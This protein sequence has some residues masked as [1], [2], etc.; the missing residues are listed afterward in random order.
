MNARPYRQQDYLALKAATRRA[1][2]E[3]GTLAEVAKHTRTH[4]SMLSKYGNPNEHEFA[5]IDVAMD[6]DALAG[7]D[8]ILRAWAEM[9][10]YDLVKDERGVAVE[11]MAQHVGSVGRESGEL[12]SEMC[13][14]LADGKV[15]PNE[16]LR[17]ENAGEDL[18][19]N[20]TRLQ[21]DC[22]RIRAKA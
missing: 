15:T 17:I 20:V 11:S 6:L 18:K 22:R 7:D 5:P 1:T 19:D 9:R 16:A 10:G 8:R 3:A 4:G 21:D 14:A 13:T 12:I 2:A